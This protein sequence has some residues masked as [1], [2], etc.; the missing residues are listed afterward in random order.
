MAK[1]R[2]GILGAT[3]TVGQ[4][5]IQLLETHPLIEVRVLG[6]SERSA[7]K[8]YKD[9][10]KWKLP[11]N[12]PSNLAES[13]VVTCEPENFVGQCD[14]VFSGLDS[15]VAG[16][17]EVAM[18][19]AGLAVFS[20]AKNHRMDKDVPLV[21]PTANLEHLK[22]IEGQRTDGLK[23]KNNGCIVCNPNCATTGLIAPLRALHEAYGLSRVNVVTMQAISGAGYPGVASLDI[24]DN[25]VPYISSEEDKLETEP[26]KILGDESFTISAQCNRV[27]V[28]DGHLECLSIE[29]GSQSNANGKRSAKP[30]IDEIKECLRNYRPS[31]SKYNLP[32]LPQT[33][34]EVMEAPDR[35]QPRLDRDL[36]KGY[37]VAVGRIRE[38]PLF[39]VRMVVL[40]H[41]TII[42]AAGGA[43][44]NA[45]AAINMGLIQRL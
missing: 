12:I 38:C 31:A 32:S 20:N 25:V 39:D 17:V 3:G 21:V 24:L 18:A 30:S 36:G 7:G 6:A 15:S 9:A 11:T 29:F 1:F 5:F 22:M 14:L 41:N 26:Q 23:Y 10:V 2:A 28:L 37:T 4:R 42:G 40:S 13:T 33:C 16:P 45:E 19:E 43:L 34:I 27:P 8:K 35:P 44:L